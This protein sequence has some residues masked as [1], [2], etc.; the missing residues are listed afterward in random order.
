MEEDKFGRNGGTGGP[1]DALRRELDEARRA[2]RREAAEELASRPLR[3]R[4]AFFFQLYAAVAVLAFAALAYLAVLTPYSSLDLRLTQALQALDHPLLARFMRLVSWPGFPPQLFLVILLPILLL[5]YLGLRREAR[6]TALAAVFTQLLNTLIKLAV[7]RPRPEAG[8][9]EVQELLSGY[10]FPSG[11][12]MFYS[13]YFGFLFFLGYT[14]LRPSWMRAALLALCAALVLFVGPSRIY[15][16]QHWASDVLG[17]YLL[18]S[19]CLAG[20]VRLYR[21]LPPAPQ[22]G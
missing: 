12:V 3:T 18:G 17:A 22:E 5:F 15:L 16:G 6:V 8:L 4:R 1:L 9:V 14:L 7:A 11:H 19:L 13:A 10:S 2:A 20:A 21:G